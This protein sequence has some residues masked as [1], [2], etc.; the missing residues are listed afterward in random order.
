LR[1]L[2]LVRIKKK[3]DLRR[4]KRIIII[5]EIYRIFIK[6]KQKNFS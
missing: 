3:T 4:K 5:P 6:K 2:K 1:I